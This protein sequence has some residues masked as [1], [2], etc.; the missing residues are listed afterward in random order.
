[1][2]LNR[3]CKKLNVKLQWVNNLATI[4]F[5]DKPCHSN[6]LNKAL[7]EYSKSQ[8]KAHAGS[9]SLQGAFLQ[10]QNVDEKI[11]NTIHYN[12]KLNDELLTFF[13]KARLNI[14]PTNFTLYIW[15]RD[16]GAKCQFCNRC[17][18]SMTHLLNG[19]HAEFGN[20]YSKRHNRIVKRLFNQLKFIDRR[21]RN[22]NN[23]NIKT[24]TL[25]H[26]KYYNYATQESP[27]LLITIQ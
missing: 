18:E 15:N 7:F 16:N 27:T 25:E 6:N 2:E 17:T 3:Y 1:M 19:C 10:I 22:Y 13:V 23:T 11:S 5:N 24:I 14:L 26:R 12:W 20:F 8:L 4:I 21:Y 9:L